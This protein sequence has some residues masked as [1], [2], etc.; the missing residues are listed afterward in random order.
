MTNGEKFKSAEERAE[1]FDEFCDNN[2]C[3]ECPLFDMR[4]GRV[5]CAFSWLELEYKEELK[6]CPLC[7]HT[8]IR[9]LKNSAGD[10]WYVACNGC[11][12]RTGGDVVK[13]MAIDAWN[14]RAK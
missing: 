5:L 7:G 10:V 2:E 4:G 3:R 12:C 9:M 8:D 13:D 14:R 1:A 6:P 11:G